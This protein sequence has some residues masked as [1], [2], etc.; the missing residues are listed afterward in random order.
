MSIT[1]E[2]LCSARPATPHRETAAK[3]EKEE[4]ETSELLCHE[5]F[6]L[7]SHITAFQ[8]RP[9]ITLGLATGVGPSCITGPSPPM[10]HGVS[11]GTMTVLDRR[12]LVGNSQSIDHM[13]F[14]F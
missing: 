7:K 12:I 13:L 6:L 11:I 4:E 2:L 9:H 5:P 10:W 1:F 14:R 8:R 3:S